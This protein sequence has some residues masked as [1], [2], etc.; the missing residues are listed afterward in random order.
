[1][2]VASMMRMGTSLACAL[3]QLRNMTSAFRGIADLPVGRLQFHHRPRAALLAT[4]C[5]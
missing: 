4:A 5:S 1:M 3:S 2:E